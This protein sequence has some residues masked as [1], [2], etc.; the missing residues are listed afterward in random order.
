MKFRLLH[1]GDVQDATS[2]PADIWTLSQ[3]PLL[4]ISYLKSI[5]SLC[6]KITVNIIKS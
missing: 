1:E 5:L 3:Y 2:E 4:V 6:E